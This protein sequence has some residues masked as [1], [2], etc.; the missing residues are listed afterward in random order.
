ME[1][2]SQASQGFILFE[3]IT[4]QPPGVGFTMDQ[5]KEAVETDNDQVIRQLLTSLRRGRVPDPAHRGRRLR[6]IPVNYDRETRAYYN[7]EKTTAENV[8][9]GVSAAILLNRLADLLSRADSFRMAVGDEGVGRAITD[10]ILSNAAA[11]ELLTQIPIPQ[12]Q[13]ARRTIDA[14]FDARWIIATAQVGTTP[15]LPAPGEADRGTAR[16]LAA[17]T[18]E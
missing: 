11:R 2:T 15:T 4:S 16:V 10:E 6:P 14:V 5:M 7:F 1:G 9:E 13:E 12:L 18:E 3:F 8:E 17:G